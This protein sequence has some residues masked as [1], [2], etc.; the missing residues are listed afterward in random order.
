MSIQLQLETQ[1]VCNAACEFCPYPMQTRKKGRMSTVLYNKI[2]DEAAGIPLITHVCLNG[3]GEPMLDP[4][5]VERVAYAH[6]A[7]KQ[8]FLFTNGTYLTPERFEALKAAG[9]ATIL[10]SL[11]ASNAEERK[12][13]MHLDDW[14]KV[15]GNILY[16][17]NHRGGVTLE[18]RAVVND[19][20]FGLESARR[21]NA[22]FGSVYDGGGYV[23]LI[24]EGN[25]A[26][27]NRLI[28]SRTFKP[29]EHCGRATG[30]IYVTWDGKV[31]TC[32]QDP[33]GDGNVFGDLNTQTIREVYAAGP[34][35]SFRL[36]HLNNE[37][38]KHPICKDC[39]RM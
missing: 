39:G 13:I 29:N 19:D 17:I 28:E 7:G 35:E 6:A 36:D 34:Y 38:D 2:V 33:F 4:Q 31:T 25:W 23:R 10:V 24:Q 14:D 5:L 27:A 32:C 21:L 18:V 30:A 22:L 20:S 16:A 15:V 1:A 11:N 12:R 26:G 8:V 37:A 9:L 3:L